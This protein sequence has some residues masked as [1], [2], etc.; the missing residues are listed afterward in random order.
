MHVRAA[1]TGILLLAASAT[2]HETAPKQDEIAIGPSEVVVAIDYLVPRGPLA[3][4]LRKIFDR[5]HSGTLDDDEEARLGAQLVR[6]AAGFLALTVDGQA[7]TMSVGAPA[8]DAPGRGDE[9]IRLHGQ[10]VARISLADGEHTIRFADHMKD[11]GLRIPTIIHL[12]PGAIWPKRPPPRI[13][14]L[15]EKHPLEVRILIVR[16]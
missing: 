8:I 14:F 6:E 4:S 2:A 1:A 16:Q 12:Q 11:P 10:A 5:D 3:A 13:Q 9:A 15:D 7:V